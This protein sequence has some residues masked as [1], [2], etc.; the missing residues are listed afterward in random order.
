MA[1]NDFQALRQIDLATGEITPAEG[2]AYPLL[3]TEGDQAAIQDSV[4]GELTPLN[5]MLPWRYASHL[6][7]GRDGLFFNGGGTDTLPLYYVDA[8]TGALTQFELGREFGATDARDGI[9]ALGYLYNS[10]IIVASTTTGR[11]IDRFYG[12][13]FSLALS[14]D[15]RR[16][17]T[18]SQG[19]TAI[20]DV[21]E[22]LGVE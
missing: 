1:F 8:T 3:V 12:T 9:A 18:T 10:H 19:M 22:Y 13:A 7:S 16:L 5:V 11:V 20:W 21:A 15:R 17:A 4:S 6:T 2:L 14:A